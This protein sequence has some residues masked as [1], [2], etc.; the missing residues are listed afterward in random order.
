MNDNPALFHGTSSDSALV[1][2]VYDKNYWQGNGKS[3]IQFKFAMDCLSEVS[4][5]LRKKNI[6]LHIFEG[7]YKVFMNHFTDIGYYKKSTNKFKRFYADLKRLK[8]YENFGIQTKNFNRDVWSSDWQQIMTKP[9]LSEVETSSPMVFKNIELNTFENFSSKL[10]LIKQI[11]ESQVGGET[12][13]FELLNTFLKE[14]LVQ[15]P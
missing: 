3:D 1:V 7:N 5:R 2:Y 13:A 9:I 14:V 8:I 15:E 10:T 6:P 4:D 11:T 12:R